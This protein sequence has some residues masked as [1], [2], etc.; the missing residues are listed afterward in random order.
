FFFVVGF[1]RNEDGNITS[2][3]ATPQ[4]HP[5]LYPPSAHP[6]GIND[7]GTIT[8]HWLGP[9]ANAPRAFVRQE[10]GTL[11]N[12]DAARTIRHQSASTTTGQ[13]LDSVSILLGPGFAALCANKTVPSRFSMLQTRPLPTRAASMAREL[14]PDTTSTPP[15]PRPLALCGI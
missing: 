4:G 11:T 7:Q 5:T 14:S 12:S 6:F 2:F 10:D 15:H 9:L 1:V 3:D 8:G 13:L